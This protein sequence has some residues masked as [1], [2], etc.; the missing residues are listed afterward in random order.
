MNNILPADF[1]ESIKSLSFFDFEKYVNSFNEKTPVSIR[2]NP[3]KISFPKLEKVKWS[4][5]GY[6]IEERPEF[7]LD[8]FWHCG[9]YYVQEAGSMFIEEILKQLDVLHNDLK[10]LDLAA[11]PGGKSTHLLSL[12][13]ENSILVSNEII[14]KRARILEENLIRWGAGNFILTNNK[15]SD[16][17]NF[18]DEF[19]IVLVDAP[20]SG[21]GMFRKDVNT[22]SEWSEDN[23]NNCSIRQLDI[24]ED[25]CHTI[26]ENGYLIYSTCTFNVKENEEVI[27]KFIEKYDFEIIDINVSIY[28]EIV[29]NNKTLRFIPGISKSEG[30]VVTVLQKKYSDEKKHFKFKK[31][32]ETD[33]PFPDLIRIK[34]ENLKFYNYQDNIHLFNNKN[35]DFLDK[36]ISNLKVLTFGNKIAKS[37]LKNKSILLPDYNLSTS[38]Y[39]EKDK[40]YELTDEDALRYLK[41]EVLR[42]DLKEK[43]YYFVTYKY[44]SIGLINNLQNRANNLYPDYCRIKKQ[45]SYNEP[46]KSF[47]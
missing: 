46:I 14:Q 27:N 24:L 4:D 11:A 37:N 42:I 5:F 18:S 13:N 32:T 40:Q 29:K 47:F 15:P 10:I 35:K 21:E 45:V 39:I 8:P 44:Q 20:C 25:I 6:Y 16:F 2:I 12:I 33:N 28:N 17:S 38:F 3:K 1:I 36:I 41:G 23:V 22:I 26:K 19:D 7:I 34:K 43:G 31:V 9:T 30:F